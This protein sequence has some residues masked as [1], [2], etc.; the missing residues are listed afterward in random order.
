MEAKILAV[1]DILSA[2]MQRRAY[3]E[4]FSKEKT[5]D[6]LQAM[7]E[8]NEIDKNI[9]KVVVENYDY[10]ADVCENVKRETNLKYRDMI[11]RYN[12]INNK[13]EELCNE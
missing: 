4:K 2:L 3:K 6:I 12:E 5:L 11:R 7:A 10:L 8:K 13:Y 9:V 1:S